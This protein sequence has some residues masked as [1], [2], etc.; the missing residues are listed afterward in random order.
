MATGISRT[1]PT[2]TRDQR[3]HHSSTERPL[4]C[5]HGVLPAKM[6][7]QTTPTAEMEGI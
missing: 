2:K 1:Q 6:P 4:Q 3:A 7:T 5:T